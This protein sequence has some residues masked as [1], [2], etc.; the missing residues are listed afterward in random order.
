MGLEIKELTVRVKAGVDD[1]AAKQSTASQEDP[2]AKMR[3]IIEQ[4]H[5]SKNKKDR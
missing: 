2:E 1:S 5:Q 3:E 4:M